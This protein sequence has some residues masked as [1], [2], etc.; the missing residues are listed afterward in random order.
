MLHIFI[1]KFCYWWEIIFCS[2][3]DKENF[4]W[5]SAYKIT[6][7][8]SNCLVTENLIRIIKVILNLQQNVRLYFHNIVI[9]SLIIPSC[10]KKKHNLVNGNTI[11]THCHNY[12]S[13]LCN[14]HPFIHLSTQ[15][16]K[17]IAKEAESWDWSF[18]NEK[19]KKAKQEK[20]KTIPYNIIV[21]TWLGQG[22]VV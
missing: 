14:I 3:L 5:N 19:E 7:I 16:A 10:H 4:N 17:R 18:V 8:A 15:P 11:R 6:C 21:P 1:L 2:A 9:Y 22:R 13:F 20:K 12:P